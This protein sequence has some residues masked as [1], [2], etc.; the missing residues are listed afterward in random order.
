LDELWNSDEGAIKDNEH[1]ACPDAGEAKTAEPINFA[2]Y[3]SPTVA[4]GKVYL[5]TFSNK[6]A[7][8]GLREIAG[9]Q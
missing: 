4:E 6:L 3:V 9:K 5:A 1:R 7:V 8:Y 2:K